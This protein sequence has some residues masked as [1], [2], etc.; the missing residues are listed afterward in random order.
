MGGREVGYIHTTED[1]MVDYTLDRMNSLLFT[2]YQDEL[3]DK[4]PF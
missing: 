2:I 4:L 3:P 1:M